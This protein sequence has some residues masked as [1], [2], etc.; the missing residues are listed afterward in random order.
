MSGLGKCSVHGCGRD[1]G[2][3]YPLLAGSPAFCDHHHTPE[4]AGRFGCDLTGPDDFDPPIGDEFS[5]L[6]FPE[7]ALTRKGFV[8]T[9]REGN[10]HRLSDIDD[11]YLGNIIS[12]LERRTAEGLSGAEQTIAFLKKE[13]K[14]RLKIKEGGA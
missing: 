4:Y 14:L 9:D 10:E 11:R 2:V 5:S 8:W 3:L 7:P 6:E 1:A 12:Y 13:V